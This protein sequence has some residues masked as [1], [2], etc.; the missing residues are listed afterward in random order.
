MINPRKFVLLGAKQQIYKIASTIRSSE[1]AL[2]NG[3]SPDLKETLGYCDAVRGL[4]GKKIAQALEVV[5]SVR[6]LDY[7]APKEKIK[8]LNFA[9]H[10]LLALL[11]RREDEDKNFSFER[12]DNLERVPERY[13]WIGILDNLRSP[14]NTGS[15]FRSADGFG[16]GELFLTGITPSP[17]NPKVSRTALGAEEFVPYRYFLETAEAVAEAKACG[18]RVVAL[19]V[20]EP[21]RHLHEIQSFENHAFVF[22]NEEF[23][24][25]EETLSLCDDAVRLPLSGRKNSLNVGNVFAVVA[26][27]AWRFFGAARE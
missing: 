3:G 17:P 24:I 2:K 4:P 13:P 23:G 27:E 6:D 10:N 26:Y 7:L 9:Y 25:T 21:A 11:D 15:I 18:Y 1:I 19:E 5:E 20:V 22:G 8:R 16:T 12:F 14:M